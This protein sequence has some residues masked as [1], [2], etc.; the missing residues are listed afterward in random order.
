MK[1]K[2][3]KLKR[4]IRAEK[5]RLNNRRRRERAL[6]NKRTRI[7][8]DCPFHVEMNNAYGTCDCGGQNYESC[9]G[10]I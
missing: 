6:E 10:D 1:R 3:K 9:L 2:D 4:K 8:M 5:R 7:G